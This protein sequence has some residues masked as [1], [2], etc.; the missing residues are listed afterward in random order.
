MEELIEIYKICTKC[1]IN[2]PIIDRE[3]MHQK[4]IYFPTELE[5]KI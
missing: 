3:K 2:K 1:K 4:Q 5:R